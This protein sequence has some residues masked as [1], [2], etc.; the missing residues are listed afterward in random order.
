MNILKAA[1]LLIV[2]IIKIESLVFQEQETI[3][4]VGLAF[5]LL[6]KKKKLENVFL[7]VIL[8]VRFLPHTHSVCIQTIS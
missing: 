5:L 8:I 3:P 1:K 6:K 4:W 2:I 7:G